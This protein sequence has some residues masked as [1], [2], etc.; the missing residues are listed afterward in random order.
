MTV[1]Q[2]RW[3][4]NKHPPCIHR[5]VGALVAPVSR[6]SFDVDSTRTNDCEDLLP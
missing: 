6:H 5:N 3:M 1:T 4:L 2:P